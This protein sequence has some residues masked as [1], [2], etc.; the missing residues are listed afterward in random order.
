MKN[1][2]VL[3][4]YIEA[5]RHKEERLRAKKENN[6]GLTNEL[7]DKMSPADVRFYKRDVE[8]DIEFYETINTLIKAEGTEFEQERTKNILEEMKSVLINFG[9]IEE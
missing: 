1:P 7:I 6:Y 9:I 4:E 8:L 3:R 5:L 2:Q